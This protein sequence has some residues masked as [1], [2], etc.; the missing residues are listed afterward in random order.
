MILSSKYIEAHWRHVGFLVPNLVVQIELYIMMSTK[1]ILLILCH[2][3]NSV[4]SYI[5]SGLNL[6]WSDRNYKTPGKC[7]PTD[8]WDSTVYPVVRT[9]FLLLFYAI[10]NYEHC[11]VH[12]P[13]LYNTIHLYS[14]CMKTLK[15]EKIKT[16]G[17][18]QQ[19]TTYFE[20]WRATNS[21]IML[22]SKK[23]PE[24]WYRKKKWTNK[25]T[26]GEVEEWCW[27]GQW[28]GQV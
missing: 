6:L 1:L 28:M 15:C 27:H 9:G 10:H 12:T 17:Q 5:I 2:V 25:Q 3:L 16:S 19:I 22:P 11:M 7:I 13:L 21:A 8:F 4:L 20:N 18:K 24:V 23:K 14:V 26:T